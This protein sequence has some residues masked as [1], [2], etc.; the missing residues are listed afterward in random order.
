MSYWLVKTEPET[1]GY[2]D[3]ESQGRDRWNGVRN[4]QALKYMRQ[5]QPGD[6]VFVYHTGKE[7]AIIGV[8]TV[9][10]LP[11]PDPEAAQSRMIVVDLAAKERLP[12]PVTLHEIKQDPFFQ[13]WELVNLPR[14]SIM[15]VQPE[16][17]EEVLKLAGMQELELSR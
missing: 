11:Y 9:V 1:Y 17:W 3:L 16:Y 10:S 15:P 13:A 14:L 5:M 12:R 6:A 2:A 4:W 7:K 8:A